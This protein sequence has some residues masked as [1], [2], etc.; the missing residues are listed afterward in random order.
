MQTSYSN[1]LLDSPVRSS[2][3][4]TGS[5]CSSLS[6]SCEL[7]PTF[8]DESRG[9]RPHFRNPRDR[10]TRGLFPPS[11]EQVERPIDV[12]RCVPGNEV[13]ADCNSSDPDWASLNLGIL[14][15]IE[16][17]GVHRNL[18][19]HISKVNLYPLFIIDMMER[20]M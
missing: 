5:D 19:V 1:R 12:L 4:C 14:L 15:C 2:Y 13:C 16:C 10:P 20:Y 9:P 17:S 18:G 11:G 8:W 7:D 3:R 6:S